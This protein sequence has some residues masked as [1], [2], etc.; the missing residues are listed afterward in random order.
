MKAGYVSKFDYEA[1]LCGERFKSMEAYSNDFLKRNQPLLTP[2][3]RKWVSDPLHQWS[4]VWEYS[5][6]SH[7]VEH[8]LQSLSR[9]GA[10]ILD[11]GSGIT[12]FPYF[13][14][15]RFPSLQMTCVDQDEYLKDMYKK[16]NCTLDL[17]VHFNA[18]P[19][20]RTL[21]PDVAFDV[22]YCVSVLEHTRNYAAI[23][24][25]F[26]RLL[27]PQGRLIVT[28]DVSLDGRSDISLTRLPGLMRELSVRFR[29]METEASGMTQRVGE[30][31]PD[32]GWVTTKYIQQ[33]RR[34]WLPWRYPKLSGA[35]AALRQGHVPDFSIKY[36]TF[37][38]LVFEK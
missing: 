5:F 7:W 23:L 31:N 1:L 6:V 34:E 30:M 33:I 35:M 29:P 13:L 28:F 38:C 18:R 11:A 4:R 17:D 37:T 27:K 8:Y 2:Y 20:D 24:D 36:L 9:P 25:E 15:S 21:L 26:L 16:V 12:F 3:A 14:K 19:M 22:I 32:A 10:S